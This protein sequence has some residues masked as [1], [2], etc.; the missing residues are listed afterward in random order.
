MASDLGRLSALGPREPW[1]CAYLF[2][3]SWDDL[4]QCYTRFR[5]LP[6]GKKVVLRGRLDGELDVRYNDK[7]VPRLSGYITDGLVQVGFSAFGDSRPI[8]NA[9]LEAPEDVILYGEVSIFNRSLTLKGVEVIPPN[10][11]GRLRPIYPGKTKVISPDTVRKRMMSVLGSAVPQAIDWLCS[12]MKRHERD[13]LAL[14]ECEEGWTLDELVK[15]AHLPRSLKEGRYAHLMFDRIAALAV[16]KRSFAHVEKTSVPSRFQALPWRELAS[17]FPFPLSMEQEVAIKDIIKRIQSPGV[18]R[19]CL[20]GDVGTGK[21]AVY[22]TV[23]AA[24]VAA[25]GRVVVMLPNE[26]LAQQIANEFRALWSLINVTYV[27]G[28]NTD[29]GDL[30]QARLL[31]GTQALLFRD[32]GTIDLLIVDE[33]QKFS[34]QQREEMLTE[35]THLLEVSATCIPRSQAL[36]RFGA[37][38]MSRLHQGHVQKTITTRIWRSTERPMA[39]SDIRDTIDQGGKVIV[40]YPKRVTDDT[41]S[42]LLPS[43]DEAFHQWNRLFPDLVRLAHGGLDEEENAVA[44]RDMVEGAGAILISTSLIEVGI[45]IPNLRRIVVVHAERFGLS[46]LH[47]IRGRVAREGGEGFCDLILP[48]KV[49]EEVEERLQI[50]CDSN[51]GF[52]VAEADMKIRGFGDLSSVSSKQ[53]GSDETF[54]Y[55]RNLQVDALDFILS[56]DTGQP[57][58]AG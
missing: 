31:V 4:S 14:V 19:H 33:Q 39:M 27:S 55:G 6:L 53:S 30:S 45:N 44:I 23:A 51:D 48:F 1:Q 29:A 11:V 57:L 5:N 41:S 21:T 2:P 47:Q 24:M 18:L 3:H 7:K 16:V 46:T 17:S 8:Q 25:G 52:V 12:S 42:V 26:P 20:S 9:I 50:L 40:V 22:F 35:G 15:R 49:K 36:L 43:A 13:L 56:R 38:S 10:W 34:R 54:L 28:S 58:I 37:I 32:I